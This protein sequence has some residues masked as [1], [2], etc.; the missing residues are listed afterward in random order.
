MHQFVVTQ[1]LAVKCLVLFVIWTLLCLT[2]IGISRCTWVLMGKFRATDF[3]AGLAHGPDWY[4]RLNRIHLNA[5][6]NLPIFASL[7]MAA[8]LFQKNSAL[9]DSLSM[10]VVLGRVFQGIFH[11]ISGSTFWV[12][13]R[14]VAFLTQVVCFII[15]TIV[16][17]S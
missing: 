2:G 10:L 9:F 3:P 8:N 16:I 11:L 4:W 14:F 15:M 6:E 7:V 12:N 17:L 5:V 1:P 13:L